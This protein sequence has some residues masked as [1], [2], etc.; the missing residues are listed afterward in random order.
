[1]ADVQ[2][3]IL[4][5][6]CGSIGGIVAASILASDQATEFDVV[7]LSRNESIAKAVNQN[8]FIFERPEGKTVVPGIVSTT[9]NNDTKPFDWIF[10]ATQP[11]QL[12]AATRQVQQF[13][14]DTGYFVCFQNGLCEQRVMT[15]VG[16]KRVLGC[17]VAWGASTVTPGTF[18]QTSY[19]GFVLGS[20]DNTDTASLKSLSDIL[21]TVAPTSLTDNLEGARW[22]KLAINCAIST[23]GTI[24]G[25]RLGPLLRH[26]FVRR[27]ALEIMTELVEVARTQAIVLQP[28]AGTFDLDWLAL[29]NAEKNSAVSPNLI[30]KHSALIAVGTRHRNMRSSMLRA[31]EN[32][33]KPAVDFLNGEVVQRGKTNHIPTP[34]NEIATAWVHDIANGER[35]SGLDTLRALYQATR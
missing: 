29:T 35:Q 20:L 31:I 15:L 17:I 6:G 33:R 32:G 18:T 5:V 30:A 34:V 28:I 27:L 10:L 14:S 9:L 7:V 8:G 1:M 25:D 11:Q 16:H 13:L 21:C 2:K 23:L 4:I 26:R 22:S 19:G 24:G 3:R 12:E